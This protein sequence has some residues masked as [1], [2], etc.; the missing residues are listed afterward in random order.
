MQSYD[1]NPELV[2]FGD[3]YFVVTSENQLYCI[4]AEGVRWKKKFVTT[5]YRDPYTDVKISAIDA[6]GGIIAAGTN[7]MD[8]KLYLM[9]EDGKKLWEHQFATIAS[10][11]WRPEDVICISIGRGFVS[12]ATRFMHDYVYAYTF[13][14]ERLFEHR[15]DEDVLKLS[16]SSSTAVLTERG[17]AVFDLKGKKIV[18]V[19]GRFC[20]VCNCGK[21]FLCGTDKDFIDNKSVVLMSGEKIYCS[22][23]RIYVCRGSTV[24]SYSLPDLQ[25]LWSLKA[26]KVVSVL[27]GDEEYL[28]TD[29]RILRVE[30][31]EIKAEMR[32]FGDPV[33]LADLGT[34]YAV[35]HDGKLRVTPLP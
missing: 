9:D 25:M 19:E 2:A 12:V 16:S 3:G 30:D 24:S 15:F 34:A 14:R 17:I 33:G 20:D 32:F 26:G 21:I 23:D 28:M 8:G 10:L 4:D 18:E 29:E 27:G 11:G 13:D 31:G 35:Y 1:I 6:A 22:S 7:F 5:F